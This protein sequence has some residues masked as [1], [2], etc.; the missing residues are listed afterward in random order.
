M[1]RTRLATLSTIA[2]PKSTDRILKFDTL[3]AILHGA[4]YT[5]DI[6][7]RAPWR[8]EYIA[9]RI[10]GYGN[11]GNSAWTSRRTFFLG[12][13]VLMSNE[14]YKVYREEWQRCW[15]WEILKVDKRQEFWLGGYHLEGVRGG[16]SLN[17]FNFGGAVQRPGLYFIFWAL[18]G[19]RHIG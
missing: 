6:R 13:W 7:R 9:N 15:V 4:L 11:E 16:H 17:P 12:D 3:S 10:H 18:L 14:E 8:K 1:A 5:W 19:R 2:Y